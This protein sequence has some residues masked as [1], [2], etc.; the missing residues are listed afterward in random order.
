MQTL[1]L[2]FHLKLT[3]IQSEGYKENLKGALKILVPLTACRYI[4]FTQSQTSLAI[5]NGREVTR[6]ANIGQDL[7]QHQAKTKGILMD[8]Y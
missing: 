1:N 2:I 7:C 4:L 6:T 5:G 3:R 8:L